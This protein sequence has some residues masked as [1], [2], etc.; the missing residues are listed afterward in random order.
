MLTERR[1]RL[2][3]HSGDAIDVEVRRYDVIGG[4]E[5]GFRCLPVSKKSIDGNVIRHLVPDGRRARA[6]G[7]LAVIDSGQCLVTDLGFFRRIERLFHGLGHHHRHGLADMT[8]LVDGQ[9]EVRADEDRTAPSLACS[10][11]SYLVFGSGSCG[12]AARPSPRQSAPLKAPST[13]GDALARERSAPRMRA[14]G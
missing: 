14:C 10:F 2:E 5:S 6:H 9:E 1:A 12:I 7:V 8:N 3:R 13:P 4:A 11:M